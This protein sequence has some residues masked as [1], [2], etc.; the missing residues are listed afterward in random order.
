[1]GSTIVRQI[2]RPVSQPALSVQAVGPAVTMSVQF[3]PSTG[4]A[5]VF[6]RELSELELR[7]AERLMVRAIDNGVTPEIA[8]R[9][10]EMG[11]GY[12]A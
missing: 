11:G 1:M 8:E 7:E 10:V 2:K 9:I 3:A 12:T 4:P 5:F 6:D